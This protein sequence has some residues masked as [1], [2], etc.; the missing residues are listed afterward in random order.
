MW[1]NSRQVKITEKSFLN[2][3]D[4]IIWKYIYIYMNSIWSGCV[5]VR[6]IH[7]EFLTPKSVYCVCF[8]HNRFLYTGIEPFLL[9]SQLHRDCVVGRLHRK[10]ICMK[11]HATSAYIPRR[12][13]PHQVSVDWHLVS[14]VLQL[15]RLILAFS[16]VIPVYNKA[17]ADSCQ[18]Y[19]IF[20]SWFCQE[21]WHYR[22][23]AT[24]EWVEASVKNPWTV[25]VD[26]VLPPTLVK[27]VK[28]GHRKYNFHHRQ[29][30][31]FF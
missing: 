28:K 1:P 21:L 26:M 14:R 25:D 3:S 11:I 24:V 17:T 8:V 9:H 6:E 4:K 23:Y 22:S 27:Q 18:L 15:V 20:H 30:L 16:I 13:H 2:T 5:V 19:W 10:Y 7:N 12:S 31:N 29:I